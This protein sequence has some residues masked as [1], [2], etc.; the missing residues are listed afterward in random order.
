[1]RASVIFR[2]DGVLYRRKQNVMQWAL[3]RWTERNIV[4]D[5]SSNRHASLQEQ[6]EGALHFNALRIRIK[7]P[8]ASHSM[9][10]LHLPIGIHDDRKCDG[11]F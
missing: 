3:L 2:V 8:D 1:M 10:G 11:A 6:L 7:P 5:E 9:R 4:F